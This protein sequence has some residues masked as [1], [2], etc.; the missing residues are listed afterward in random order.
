MGNRYWYI[1]GKFNSEKSLSFIINVSILQK[2]AKVNLFQSLESLL[3]VLRRNIWYGYSVLYDIIW[4][5]LDDTSHVYLLDK[6]ME[7]TL[8]K[9]QFY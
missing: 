1:I 4:I 6:S 2:S 9:I 5:D 7:I 3:Y 8:T